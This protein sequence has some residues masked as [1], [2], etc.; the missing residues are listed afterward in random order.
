MQPTL[1]AGVAMVGLFT[2]LFAYIGE[3]FRWPSFL[4]FS[5]TTKVPIQIFGVNGPLVMVG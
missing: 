3:T 1:P 5:V 4:R 2:S